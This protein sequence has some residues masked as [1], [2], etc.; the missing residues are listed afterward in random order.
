MDTV[1]QLDI[2]K[3]KQQSQTSGIEIVAG[4]GISIKRNGN[5]IIVSL[6]EKQKTTYPLT[7][8][9]NGYSRKINFLTEGYD[10]STDFPVPPA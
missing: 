5:Q 10:Y 1:N 9:V 3:I 8:C 6:A 4:E 7:V 2:D